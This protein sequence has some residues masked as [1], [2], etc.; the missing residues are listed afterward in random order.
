MYKNLLVPMDGSPLAEI[1]LP[2]VYKLSTRFDLN[3]TFLHICRERDQSMFMCEAYVDRLA[4]TA[5]QYTKAKKGSIKAMTVSGNVVEGILEQAGKT[6]SDLILMAAHGYSGPTWVLGSVV[7][8]VLT[9]SKR[10]VLVVREELP[11]GAGGWPQEAIVPLDG[12]TLSEAVLPHVV[13]LARTGVRVTLLRVCEPPVLLADY[14]D[15]IM[16]DNWEEHIKVAQRG[17]EKMCNVYLDD[18][19]KDKLYKEGVEANSR[20][21]LAN[22]AANG[23]IEDVGRYPSA[24]VVMSTHGRSGFSR[25]P[26]G[27]VADRVLL[28]S[29]NPILL[30]RPAKQ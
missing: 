24:L 3:V 8:K 2:Y 9:A 15:S 26:Y 22:G 16:P 7:H 6:D 5:E 29:G 20:V 4:E 30:V 18:V 17:A 14:P 27:H 19:V 28:A 12:S 25:W 1:A 13:A 23:I 11:K 21:V 10:P